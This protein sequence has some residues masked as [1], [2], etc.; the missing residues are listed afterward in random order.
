LQGDKGSRLLPRAAPFL[1]VGLNDYS[2]TTQRPC[3]SLA[4]DFYTIAELRKPVC[5]TTI[6][7]PA[8]GLADR[9]IALF[10][11]GTF[12]VAIVN[13]LILVAANSLP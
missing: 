2:S 10:A 4:H 3:A 13:G 1:F 8:L 9:V 11:L 7:L 5:A 12:T 6:E